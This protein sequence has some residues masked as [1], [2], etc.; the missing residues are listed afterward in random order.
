MSPAGIT[1]V[2]CHSTMLL[3]MN[4]H[5]VPVRNWVSAKPWMLDAWCL[6]ISILWIRLK[7][8]T[9]NYLNSLRLKY[10]F[11]WLK[12]MWH[13]GWDWKKL[14]FHTACTCIM[15]PELVFRLNSVYLPRLVITSWHL[16][17]FCANSWT[18]S[19]KVGFGFNVK[20]TKF[21]MHPGVRL[22]VRELC[23]DLWFEI[24]E[25]CSNL[26]GWGADWVSFVVKDDDSNG[27]EDIQIT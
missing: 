17:L 16:V 23:G 22:K 18:T 9:L 11:L 19:L 26:P 25:P 1:V 3:V 24:L 4:H 5:M 14:D 27:F 12:K 6:S 20:Q 10:R 8:Q 13:T 7:T 21:H 15:F 2:K